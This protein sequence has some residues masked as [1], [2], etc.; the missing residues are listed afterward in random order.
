VGIGFAVPVNTA[1]RVVNELIQYGKVR[2]GW[3]DAT[4]IP[5]FADLVRYAK[6]PVSSGLLVSR[7]RRGGLADK[8]GL[9]QGSDPVQYRRT[10]I[11]LGGDII[12]SVDGMKISNESDL[13]SALE[14]S[15]PGDKVKVGILRGSTSLTLEIP[16]A[17]REE[18][19]NN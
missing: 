5:L 9:R 7:T 4:M 3:F 14:H 11:Y 8:A 12:T 10:V 16:L 17:D 1:T 15:K 18:V 2:R 6:L 13:F 19:M